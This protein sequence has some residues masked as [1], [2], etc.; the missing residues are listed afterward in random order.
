MGADTSRLYSPTEESIDAY[1]SRGGARLVS[2]TTTSTTVDIAAGADDVPGV[3]LFAGDMHACCI[4][5]LKPCVY[6]SAG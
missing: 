5:A 2:R 6:S 1:I 4:T 3:C